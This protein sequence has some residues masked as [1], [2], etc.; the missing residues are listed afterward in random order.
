[1]IHCDVKPDN[2]LLDENL[3][4]KVC[5]FAGSSLQGSRALVC[6]STRFWRPTLPKTPCDAQDDIFGLG[7]TIYMILTGKEPFGDLESDEVEMRFSAAEF[8]DTVGLLF[9][10]VMQACWR[11]RASIEEVRGLIETGTRKMQKLD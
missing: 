5:D 3:D 9:D 4:L 7:S 6:S 2:F 8:P 1:M 10:D 11:G